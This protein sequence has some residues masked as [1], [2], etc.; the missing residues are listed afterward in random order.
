MKKNMTI[1]CFL[2][3]LLTLVFTGCSQ[4][5][6]YNS[7]QESDLKCDDVSSYRV[8][9]STALKTADAMLD[10]LN[11]T[12]TR[13][14]SRLVKNVEIVTSGNVKTRGNEIDTLF[15][16][17]NYE[18]NG[19]FALLAADKRMTPVYAISDEG[20]LSM[21]DTIEH[22]GLA[23]MMRLAKAD[24]LKSTK[25]ENALGDTIILVNPPFEIKP[26]LVDYSYPRIH[27]NV[28]KW[29]GGTPIRSV[30]PYYNQE[31]VVA[32]Q[33]AST[34]SQSINSDI[35]SWDY[36]NYTSGQ[37]DQSLTN[38]S[39]YID[40]I[41]HWMKYEDETDD[42]IDIRNGYTTR[43]NT[44]TYTMLPYALQKSHSVAIDPY[45]PINN[46]LDQTPDIKD[47]IK[48]SALIMHAEDEVEGRF[49]TWCVDGYLHYTD[50]K[51]Q[52]TQPG[53]PLYFTLYH[54]VWGEF[55]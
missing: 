8:P 22:D 17:V 4:E 35:F 29:G 34:I 42:D 10:Q 7:Y 46:I 51:G 23:I 37:N 54:C 31:V 25:S 6:F 43:R 45:A 28:R 40:S 32:A 15:Y 11:G 53:S 21:N 13:S 14:S 30:K 27:K 55:G 3:M 19:G 2:V 16:L 9:L 24:A 12:K 49:A 18:N 39:N 33:A 50:P 26:T 36:S 52:M 44:E 20:S 38:V 41:I 5:E 1:F 47:R 48:Q